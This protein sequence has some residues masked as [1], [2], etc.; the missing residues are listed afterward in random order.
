ML[1][2][3]LSPISPNW[4]LYKWDQ[5]RK[6]SCVTIAKRSSI[7]N[8]EEDKNIEAGGTEHLFC[9]YRTLNPIRTSAEAAFFDTKCE[10]YELDNIHDSENPKTRIPYE[11]LNDKTAKLQC[12]VD[13]Y[14]FLLLYLANN[15]N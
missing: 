14:C 2:L 10:N 1:T 3:S 9:M 12:N 6:Q 8:T 15:Y 5:T 4:K 13:I 11:E 7:N